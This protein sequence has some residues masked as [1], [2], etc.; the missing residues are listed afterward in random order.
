[1]EAGA[2]GQQRGI[3]LRGPNPRDGDF[4][5]LRQVSDESNTEFDLDNELPS[6]RPSADSINRLSD[7]INSI[8]QYR[9]TS[10][11]APPTL[12][13]LEAVRQPLP[14]D[15]QTSPWIPLEEGSNASD[16]V[17]PGTLDDDSH[18]NINL[19][20]G[21]S[22]FRY[23]TLPPGF[24]P[25]VPHYPMQVLPGSRNARQF[26]FH[27]T[28]QDTMLLGD[29]QGRVSVL[30]IEN[31]EVNTGPALTVDAT[32]QV[33]GLIWLQH[34]TQMAACGTAVSGRIAFLRYEPEARPG[35]AKVRAVKYLQS[36][37]N[38]TSL[39]A[40]CTDDFLLATGLSCSV[41]VYDMHTGQVAQSAQV[42]HEHF[43][44]IGRFGNSTP[45]MFATAS[46]DNTC[47]IWDL[48][49][50]LDSKQCIKTLNTNGK[51][52]MCTFSPDDRQLL[53]SGVDTRILQYEVGSWRRTPENFQLRRPIYQGRYRRS[54][55]LEHS[56]NIVT[57]ATEESYMRLMSSVTGESLGVI[58]I[59]GVATKSLPPLTPGPAALT[60]RISPVRCFR[61]PRSTLAMDVEKK[62]TQ[63]VT[64]SM[65][66][67]APDVL[68]A[69]EGQSG[70]TSGPR[71]FIQSLRA[72]KV[73]K[74]RVGLL[75]CHTEEPTAATQS[76]VALAHLEPSC[77]G[78]ED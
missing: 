19:G 8:R 18:F 36:F 41:T 14:F 26:E 13:E 22:G 44:N 46:Y 62:S 60:S 3:A 11:Q 5:W 17:V 52:V 59:A 31:P 35:A 76:C 20:D 78:W 55:Y 16:I 66:T 54:M 72:H 53:C 40:N 6:E 65:A 63:L 10:P 74:N 64:G 38:L 58:D 70:R 61:R 23:G 67:E 68:A 75:L 28:L 32:S 33:L 29:K 25:I 47:R 49:T 50:N 24:E 15:R 34:H 7:Q 30:N 71:E 27:P 45:H 1:M 42:V 77:I 9:Q 43:V 56:P 4:C 21:R 12:A 37:P 57:A 48:R 51:N 69:G 39:S 73:V 2:G